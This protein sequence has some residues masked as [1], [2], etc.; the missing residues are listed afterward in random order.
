MRERIWLIVV[1][2]AVALWVG[3]TGREAPVESPPVKATPTPAHTPGPDLALEGEN[4]FQLV[5]PSQ[6]VRASKNSPVE[7]IRMSRESRALLKVNLDQYSSAKIRVYYEEEQPQG[8]TLNIGDS[9]TNNGYSGDSGTQTRDCEVQIR[10]GEMSIWGSDVMVDK[11]GRKLE[12]VP[13]FAIPGGVAEFEISDGTVRWTNGSQS[14]ELS[15]DFLFALNGQP[16]REGPVNRDIYIGINQVV[17]G[18]PRSGQGVNR[19]EITGR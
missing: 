1:V 18:G 12:S 11:E 7:V 16:D 15:S 6:T 13:D 8:W 3:V 2:V 17:A 5:L 14:G 9:R 19:V 4:H 10:N